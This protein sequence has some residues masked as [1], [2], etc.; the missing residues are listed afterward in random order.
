M[1]TEAEGLTVVRATDQLPTGTGGKAAR[2]DVDT[3]R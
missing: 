1:S 2:M 3:G